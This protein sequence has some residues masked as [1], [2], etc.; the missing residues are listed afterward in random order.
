MTTEVQPDTQEEEF[1]LPEFT[2]PTATEAGVKALLAAR[3][4]PDLWIEKILDCALWAKQRE[5]VLSVFTNPRTTVRSCTGSG[6]SFTAA[7]IA[8]AFLCNYKPIYSFNNGADIPAGG[9]HLMAGIADG[10][11]EG[12]VSVG[13]RLTATRLEMAENWFALGLST[14]EPERFQGFHSPYMLVIGD[15]AAGLGEMVYNAIETPLSTGHARLLLISNPTQP[16]GKFRDTFDSQLYRHFNISAFDTPNFVAFGITLEDIKTG[17]WKDKIGIASYQIQDGTWLKKL[18]APYLVTPLWV[19]ERLEEWGEGSFMFQVYVMGDF[20]TKG[21]N[22]LFNLPEVEAAIG[23]KVNDEG[24]LAAALDPARYGGCES[25]YGLR[26]GEGVIK[27]EAWGHEGIHYTTGRTIRRLREDGPACIH[28]DAGGIGADDCDI[29]ASEGF[30]VDRVL[31][32]APAVDKERF[33]NRRA[34][35]YWLLS[36]RFTDGNISIPDDRLLVSQ[37]TDIRYTY[38]NGK[39]IMESKE[40]MRAR[41]SKSPDR[42]DML[43]L[44]FSPEGVVDNI[45]PP[46][47]NTW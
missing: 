2:F 39:M 21:A 13:G 42:A 27:I 10:V 28:I 38:H 20:P 22:N 33:A 5:I 34:E 25:V 9:E 47:W 46:V 45:A 12:E 31:S 44:L 23:R 41:G 26:R 19:K 14:D 30:N 18:P 43:A 37:L 36:R 16:V 40:Q 1:L 7:R 11:W 29:I 24:E 15:E 35:L 32:N 17:E 4:R 6:K 3:R 8:L